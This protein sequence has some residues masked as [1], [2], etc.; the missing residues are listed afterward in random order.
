SLAALAEGQGAR[1]EGQDSEG[2]DELVPLTPAEGMGSESLAPCPSPLAPTDEEIADLR[3]KI[4]KLGSVNL[5]ALDELADVEKRETEMR[6]QCA[7]LADGQTK[8]VQIIE[9]INT[10][11]RALFAETMAAVRGHFQDLFRKL[12]GGGMADVVLEDESDVLES[13]I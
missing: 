1:G 9:Q 11:S 8:L 7:D 3:K 5:E 10:D 2:Q 4:A 13:G 6:T 12:F